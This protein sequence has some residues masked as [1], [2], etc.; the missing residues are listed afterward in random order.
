MKSSGIVENN[1]LISQEKWFKYIEELKKEIPKEKISNLIVLKKELKNS[2]IE[3]VKKRIPGEK[4]GIFFS[5]GVDST[6]IAF[7]CKQQKA[8]FICYTVGLENAPDI[9][10][11]QKAANKIGLELKFKI[12]RLD[13][14]KEIIEK[15]IPLV[16][17]NVMKVG[18][19][20]VVYAAAEFAKKDNIKIFFSGLGSEEIFAG[21]ERHANSKD[22]NEECWEGLKTMY[23]RDFLRDF[24]VAKKLNFEVLAP[25]LEKEVIKIA[26][27]IPG[28]E[29]IKKGIK[30][31]VLREI[32]Q[33]IGLDK[34]FAWR[35][36]KAAQFGSNFEKG[37]LK[38]AK[39]EGFKE[40]KP[41]LE[42]IFSKTPK[43][44]S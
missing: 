15:V 28:T 27:Q 4:F 6:L 41:Y 9:E 43:S 36:K 38:I 32:A 29:K 20:S 13:E 26:M 2:I 25:F 19:A 7:I 11:A 5:G 44:F 39:A 3:A 35:K 8:D 37:I 17:A 23:E 1:R 18:V 33:E 16:G 24:S 14:L 31:F 30:K 34:E 10:A 21:Y 12:L 42:S 40:R 22:I